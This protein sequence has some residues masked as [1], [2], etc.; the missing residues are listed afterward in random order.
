MKRISTFLLVGAYAFGVFAL[1]G[2]VC[3]S[4]AAVAVPASA[5]KGPPCHRAASSKK[6]P[7]TAM[8]CCLV[9]EAE[10]SFAPVPAP[11]AP[12]LAWAGPETFSP[13]PPLAGFLPR[14][15]TH[16]PPGQSAGFLLAFSLRA[17]PTAA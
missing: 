8:V 4:G 13:P 7:C 9:P 3:P 15:F 10:R 5:A 2:K 14:L 6:T 12:A 1:P 17:P 11:P 16:P